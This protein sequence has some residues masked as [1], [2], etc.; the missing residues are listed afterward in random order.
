MAHFIIYQS[1][2]ENYEE[3]L[4]YFKK[5]SDTYT[6][7]ENYT[8]KFHKESL[9]D[10]VKFISDVETSIIAFLPQTK[11]DEIAR[12]IPIGAPGNFF[13]YSN[14]LSIFRDILLYDN[15]V[16]LPYKCLYSPQHPFVETLGDNLYLKNNIADGKTTSN[17][18]FKNETSILRSN[19]RHYK[20]ED[21][22][23]MYIDKEKTLNKEIRVFLYDSVIDWSYMDK[24]LETNKAIKIDEKIN[25]MCDE[26]IIKIEEHRNKHEFVSADF[27]YDEHG[28]PKLLQIN[29]GFSSG[30]Y[31]CNVEKI[32]NHIKTIFN[33]K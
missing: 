17:N 11:L 28:E 22:C 9:Y 4:E 1:L 25:I 18:I 21:N 30:F 10:T 13:Q 31:N 12:I 27:C 20:I 7:M 33:K 23:M 26:I 15:G 29:N 2:F 3:V 16:F 6:D 8:P 5:S 24:R 19:K 32:F 14:I